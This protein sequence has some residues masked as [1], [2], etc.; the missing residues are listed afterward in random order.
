M[1]MS[2]STTTMK[3]RITCCVSSCF[4]VGAHTSFIATN[5]AVHILHVE[6]DSLVH[7]MA[8]TFGLTHC[9]QFAHVE[10]FSHCEV[11]H[12]IVESF[13]ALK[14]ANAWRALFHAQWVYMGIFAMQA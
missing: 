10:P 5:P 7:A 8:V 11:A 2:I 12:C 9:V 4:G 1:Q 14:Y 3:N 13:N 6:S